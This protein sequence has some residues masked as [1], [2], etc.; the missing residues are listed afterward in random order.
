MHVVDKVDKAGVGGDGC[1]LP[2]A[3]L[4]IN[5]LLQAVQFCRN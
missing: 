3:Q 4:L 1:I 5:G 2:E